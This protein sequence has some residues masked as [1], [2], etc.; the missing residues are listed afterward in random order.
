MSGGLASYFGGNGAQGGP[1]FGGAGGASGAAAVFVS[2]PAF[3]AGGQGSNNCG[4][5]VNVP[6]PAQPGF[7]QLNW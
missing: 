1:V 2:P 6:A 7:V 4:N 3:G 5:I